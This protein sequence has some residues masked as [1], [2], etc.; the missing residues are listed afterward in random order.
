LWW[1]DTE[2]GCSKL[3]NWKGFL[4]PNFELVPSWAGRG[5]GYCWTSCAQG[6]IL[7]TASHTYHWPAKGVVT[8]AVITAVV[9]GGFDLD[10][11]LLF[12]KADVLLLQVGVCYWAVHTTFRP[13]IEGKFRHLK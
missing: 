10:D 6:Q 9:A 11:C 12:S 2:P 8:G 7:R 4:K 1:G 5:P 13:V 3:K